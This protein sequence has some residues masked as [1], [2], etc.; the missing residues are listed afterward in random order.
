MKRIVIASTHAEAGKTSMLIGLA[1][2]LSGKKAIGYMKPFGDRL[3]YQKKRLWDYD[4]ALVTTIL[5]LQENPENISIGFAHDKLR[6]M[7]NEH[8]TKEKLI[9]LCNLTGQ[10]K[11]I[12]FIEG[13]KDLIY[14][15]SVYLDP[16]TVAKSTNSNLL[17]VLSGQNEQ[18]IDEIMFLR[19]FVIT[20]NSH[21]G[22]II[23]KVKDITEFKDV[24]LERFKELDVNVLGIIPY[25]EKLTHFTMDYLYQ[26]LFAKVIAGEGGLQNVVHHIFVG[27]MSAAQVVTKPLWSL[28][29]KL[30]ITP[31]DRPDMILAALESNTAGI[32]LTNNLLPED[33]VI[34]SKA[35]SKNISKD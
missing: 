15:K 18:I 12:L 23:N 6:F 17:L 27:A 20:E 28:E 7:Y 16:L 11:D 32:V 14:G 9:E 1:K 31:G 10:D 30:I 34:H 4:A 21:L 33:P 5:N 35:D 22:V 3:L 8:S 25:N 19:Q 13:G 24:Y 29:N 2:A 26:T